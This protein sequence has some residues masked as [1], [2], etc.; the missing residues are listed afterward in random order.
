LLRE[1]GLET[2]MK[3][4]NRSRPLLRHPEG[5]LPSYDQTGRDL[6]LLHDSTTVG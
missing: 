4:A 5:E 1:G 3:I 2:E 6:E